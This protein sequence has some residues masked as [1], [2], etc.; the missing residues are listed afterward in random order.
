M[1]LAGV[2]GA[3]AL[4]VGLGLWAR[5]NLPQDNTPVAPEPP[6]AE[7]TRAALQIV[8]DDAPAPVGEL[9]EVLPPDPRHHNLAP[10]GPRPE[11]VAPRRPA[12]GLVK[13]DAPIAVQPLPVVRLDTP[14][15]AE[16]PV[17]KARAA[18]ARPGNLKTASTEPKPAKKSERAEVDAKPRAE[19]ARIEKVEKEVAETAKPSLKKL[20][21]A[22]KAA[23]KAIEAKAKQAVRK[24]RKTELAQ[25]KAKPKKVE[26][27]AA[28][29]EK[30]KIE[31]AKVE[32]VKLAKAKP[33][34]ASVKAK[35]KAEPARVQVQKK[36]P[37]RG[38]GPMRVAQAPGRCV[39]ADPGEAMVCA[40]GRLGARDRQL[41]QAYRNAEAAGV[42]ASA[43]RRQQ[44]RWLQARAAAARD[45]PWA[46]EDVYVARIAELNDLTQDAREN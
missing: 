21:K 17:T 42:P 41:Q 36:P 7:A 28:K 33:P 46:V 6:A 37:S 31:K 18:E 43:L 8:I 39:N 40:D 5:P 44:A 13:V 23:P 14:P 1:V 12:S 25:A 45:A 34:P 29:I 26:A 9:L 16:A 10:F 20:A 32:K 3:C 30:A 2:L 15:K 35:P 38:E 19:K 4:G 11:P 24:D 22:V 27:K